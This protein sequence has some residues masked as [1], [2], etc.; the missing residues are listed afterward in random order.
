MAVFCAFGQ[1]ISSVLLTQYCSGDNMEKNEMGGARSAYGGRRAVYRVLGR[2]TL[3]NEPLGRLSHRWEDNIKMDLQ[4]VECGFMDWIELAQDRD[5]WRTLVNAAMS[6][7]VPTN[8]RN[9]LTS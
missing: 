4:E 6:L 9:F 1:T 2:E 3:V 5:R 7:R 8:G